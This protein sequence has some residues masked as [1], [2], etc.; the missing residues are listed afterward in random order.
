MKKI[1]GFGNSN[2]LGCFGDYSSSNQ[3]CSRYCVLRLRCAIAQEQNLRLELLEE[4][5]AAEQMTITIQ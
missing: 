5:M 4:V 2:E 3:L 1:Q